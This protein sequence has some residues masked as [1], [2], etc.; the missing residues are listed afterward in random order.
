MLLL[1]AKRWDNA[2]QH[3]KET[4]KSQEKNYQAIGILEIIFSR[5]Y[6]KLKL[7]YPRQQKYSN[8]A[9]HIYFSDYETCISPISPVSALVAFKAAAPNEL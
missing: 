9:C 6:P 2:G 7:K 5:Q 1:S 3:E 8:N 4:H